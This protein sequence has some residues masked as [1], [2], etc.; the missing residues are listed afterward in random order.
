M[1]EIAILAR[2]GANIRERRIR[3][4]LSLDDLEHRAHVGRATLV[5]AEHTGRMNA[6]TLILI[7]RALGCTVDDLLGDIGTSEDDWA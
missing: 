3:A 7:A 2:A 1:D 6:K 4:Q 5:N